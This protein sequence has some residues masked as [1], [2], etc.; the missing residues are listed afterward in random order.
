MIYRIALGCKVGFD[1]GGGSVRMESSVLW[2]QKSKIS[3]WTRR[4]E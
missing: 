3:G 1:G 2:L 4:P